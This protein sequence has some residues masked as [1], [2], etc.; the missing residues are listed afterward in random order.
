MKALIDFDISHEEFILVSNDE[1]S[2][3]NPKEIIK[4]KDIQLAEIK[5]DILTKQCKRIGIDKILKQYNGQSLK[6]KP[7]YMTGVENFLKL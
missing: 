3:L 6:T 5:R 2:Y 4:T 1:Q 7:K